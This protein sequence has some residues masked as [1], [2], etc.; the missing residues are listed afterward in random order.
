MGHKKKKS[1][2]FSGPDSL[3]SLAHCLLKVSN[4]HL[5]ILLVFQLTPTLKIL[6]YLD[7]MDVRGC[8]TFAVRRA[9]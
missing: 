3:K 6:N 1:E 8:Q 9:A 7:R 5:F 2:I 4:A